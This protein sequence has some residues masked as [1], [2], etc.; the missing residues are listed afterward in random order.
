MIENFLIWLFGPLLGPLVIG[1]F[2][3]SAFIRGWV[4]V[5]CKLGDG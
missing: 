1:I 5:A 4:W 3:F 2:L